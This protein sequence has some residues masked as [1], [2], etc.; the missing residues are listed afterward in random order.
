MRYILYSGT[1]GRYYGMMNRWVSDIN[2]AQVF[3]NRRH[4]IELRDYE[5]SLELSARVR[6]LF[7]ESEPLGITFTVVE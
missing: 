6:K 3:Y 7:K 5:L 2:K 4:A 1:A